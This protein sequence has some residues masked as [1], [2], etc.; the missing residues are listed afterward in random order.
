M[1]VPI[2]GYAGL[3]GDWNPVP[4]T[5][6]RCDHAKYIKNLLTKGVEQHDVSLQSLD[7]D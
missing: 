6:E 3:L 1:H 7:P 5:Y 4:D 2:L